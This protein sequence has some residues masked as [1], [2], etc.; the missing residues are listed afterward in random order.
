M[1]ATNPEPFVVVSPGQPERRFPNFGSAKHYAISLLPGD[2]TIFDDTL[3]LIVLD[4]R[5][6]APQE[7]EI[8]S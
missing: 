3:D 4:L 7:E 5:E 8:F 2:V 1:N 6:D